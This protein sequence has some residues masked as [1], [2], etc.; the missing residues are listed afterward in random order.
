MKHQ[1]L[2]YLIVIVLSIGAGVA[3]AGLPSSES[4]D[5]TIVPPSTTDAPTPTLAPVTTVETPATTEASTT[6]VAD[7]T[8]T[9]STTTTTVPLPDRSELGVVVANGAEIGGLAT[10]T[11]DRLTGIGY[12]DVQPT[13]GLVIV[14]TTIVYYADGFEPSAVRLAEDLELDPE[15]VAPIDEA[16]EI[17]GDFTATADL[18]VYIGTDLVDQ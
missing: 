7:S 4:V 8:T 11:A 1:W 18:L 12:V 3:V 5:P 13:D 2:A 15:N 6:T 9:T 10:S 16:P 17:S 14:D